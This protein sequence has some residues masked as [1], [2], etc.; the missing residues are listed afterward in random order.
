MPNLRLPLTAAICAKA[1]PE[2]REYSL[3]DARQPGLSLRIQSGGTKAWIVRRRDAGGHTKRTLGFHP[4]MDI[5][6][7][8]KAAAAFLSDYLPAPALRSTT[9]LFSQLQAEHEI[10]HAARLKP[11]GLATYRSYVRLQLLPAFGAMRLDEITRPSV[12]RWFEGYS[13]TSP[14]GAN[15]ALGIL[16]QMLNCARLWGH[17]PSDGHNPVSNIRFNRS[18]AVGTFLSVEQM[19]RLGAVLMERSTSGC[20]AADLLRFLSLTGCRVGEAITL[21]WPDV[22]PDRLCL[23]D[24][25]TGARQVPLGMAAR[26]LL[27]SIQKRQL[28]SALLAPHGRVFALGGGDAYDLVRRKW[29]AARAAAGLPQTLR[30]HDLRHSFASHAIMSGE[31]LLTTSRLL[32]HSRLETTARYAHLA[33]A[34]LSDSAEK[35]GALIISQAAGW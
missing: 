18:K 5:K 13:E 33:D 9:L 20:A 26:R 23:R 10:R 19:E 34:M 24:S 2:T 32:G 29:H 14:G 1:M 16:G 17:L 22:L 31:T 35:I 28:S 12:L 25:K 15:R 6:E 27:K 11:A 3:H 8:R 30:I 7:A 21:E 4:V